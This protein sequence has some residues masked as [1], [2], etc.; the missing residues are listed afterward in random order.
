MGEELDNLRRLGVWEVRTV[1]LGKNVL[2]AKWVFARKMN[3]DG[4]P[5]R[6]KARYVAKGFAQVRGEQFGATFSPTATFVSMRLILLLAALN[7]W[8]VHTFDFVAAYLNSPINEE[9]WVAAP[10]GLEVK[11]GEAFLLKKAL[12]GTRQAAHC[13]WQHLSKTLNGLGYVSSQYNGSVVVLSSIEG[14]HVIWIHMDDGIITAPS[15]TILRNLEKALSES[16][17][18]KWSDS[19]TNIV[20]LKVEQ[21]VD[22]FQVSQPKLVASILKGHWDGSS[23]A[24]TPLPTSPLPTTHKGEG[25]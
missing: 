17:E 25:I 10:E 20:G 11:K 14:N 21:S 5:I 24:K 4:H 19:L 16:I 13:W 8:P 12:Y 9:V 22:G 6:F 15:S 7:N 18:I 2:K 1:P 3:S 23:T